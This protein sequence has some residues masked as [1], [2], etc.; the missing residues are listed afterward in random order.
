MKQRVIKYIQDFSFWFSEKR[1]EVFTNINDGVKSS[2]QKWIL[3]HPHVI[4]YPITN[5]YIKVGLY[6]GNVGVSTEL[7][8]KSLLRVSICTFHI[9]MLK[10]DDTRFYI[11]YDEKELVH[12]SDY[13]I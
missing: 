13:A 8:Q 12:S 1:C 2:L 7:F 9:D 11:A 5:D 4:Q 3:F 6:Y 10:K